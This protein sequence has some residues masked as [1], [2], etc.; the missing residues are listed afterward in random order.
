[1]ERDPYFLIGKE[2]APTLNKLLPLTTIYLW[3]CVIIIFKV[4]QTGVL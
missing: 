3:R 2:Q 4:P 1:M